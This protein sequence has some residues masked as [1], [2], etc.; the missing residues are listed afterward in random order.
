MSDTQQHAPITLFDAVD[1]ETKTSILQL[2]RNLKGLVFELESR[3]ENLALDADS[4]L[5]STQQ[6][7]LKSTLD[8]VNKAIDSIKSVVD[9][10]LAEGVDVET[11]LQANASELNV[12]RELV[13][14]STDKVVKIKKEFK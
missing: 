3:M 9:L 2:N 10:V 1:K 7:Q 11:F 13:H 12:L 6:V 5:K 14:S 4:E 8:E